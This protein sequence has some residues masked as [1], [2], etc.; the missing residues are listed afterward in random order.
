MLTHDKF[1]SYKR[2]GKIKNEDGSPDNV[3]FYNTSQDDMIGNVPP[4]SHPPPISQNR[5]QI[6]D[7]YT[8]AHTILMHLM[9]HIETH[10]GLKAGTMASLN[11]LDQLSGTSLRFLKAP[12]LPPHSAPRAGFYGHTDLGS[13]TML[14]NIVGGLQVLVPP[15]AEAIESNY[16]YVKPQP[17]CAIINLGDAMVPWSGGLLRSNMHRIAMAPG[18]QKSV[19]RYSVA[20][21][22]RPAAN[23]SMRRLAKVETETG[24]TTREEPGEKDICAKDWEK[25]RVARILEGNL[26]QVGVAQVKEV[27]A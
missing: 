5:P 8:H 16:R 6:K 21:L 25:M 24:V 26:K 10:L 15:D 11:P 22:M 3:E 2:I 7:F 13:M 1:D 17:G 23:V 9:S 4:F 18:E 14:F 27:A 12:A 20:Y 19:D